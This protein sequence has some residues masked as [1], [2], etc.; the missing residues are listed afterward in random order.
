M[1]N[2]LIA[3]IIGFVLGT[4]K[5]FVRAGIS[6]QLFHRD[7]YEKTFVCP[8]CGARFNVK[9]YQMIYKY[10]T[11]YT[12]NAARLR[13]PVCHKKDMCSISHDER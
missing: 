13:C 1:K 7:A 5:F 10:I 4:F 8:S 11:V 3:I 6:M 9:W 12:Y 2:Y